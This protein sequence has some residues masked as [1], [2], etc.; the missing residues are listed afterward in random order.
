VRTSR[1]ELLRLFLGLRGR[2]EQRLDEVSLLRPP[3]RALSL[4]LDQGPR[5]KERPGPSSKHRNDREARV[6][7]FRPPVDFT[8]S[9]SDV[10]ARRFLALAVSKA[11]L[12]GRG[13]LG[14][15]RRMRDLAQLLRA[16]GAMTGSQSTLRRL[17]NAGGATAATVDKLATV[18]GDKNT[19]GVSVATS[20]A[21]SEEVEGAEAQACARQEDGQRPNPTIGKK[22]LGLPRAV[23]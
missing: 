22:W 8:L 18:R 7:G 1:P 16:L 21:R 19:R 11:R 2:Q 9:P 15:H 13:D 17:P 4:V 14:D 23:V 20:G 5:R 3:L 6:R 12:T 10:S